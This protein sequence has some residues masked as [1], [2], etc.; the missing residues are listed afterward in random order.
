[1][2][3][4]PIGDTSAVFVLGGATKVLGGSRPLEVADADANS[5]VDGTSGERERV[6]TRLLV[7]G[8]GLFS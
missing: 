8:G 2:A 3:P 6:P 5:L 7:E 1:M 4:L